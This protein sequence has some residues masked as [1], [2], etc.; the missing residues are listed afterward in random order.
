[1]PPGLYPESARILA[2]SPPKA[3]ALGIALALSHVCRAPRWSR[4]AVKQLLQWSI[5]V[6]GLSMDVREVLKAGAEG[7]LFAAATIV[8]SFVL[9][10]LLGRWLKTD[11]KL[12]TLLSAGTAICGGS[13]IAAVAPV[14]AASSAQTSVAL[15]VVFVLNG[16][17]LYIFPPLGHAL[18]LTQHQFGTWAAVAIH[19]TSSVVGAAAVYG[20]GALQTAVAVKLSRAL[21]IAPVVLAAA[22]WL[23]RRRGEGDSEARVK[24]PIP[25]FIGL[26]IIACAINGV[27][28]V[29]EP[30]HTD[31]QSIGKAGMT[32][33]L[34]LIGLGLSRAAMA[35]VGWRPLVQAVVVW[36]VLSVVSLVVIKAAGYEPPG[37]TPGDGAPA[38]VALGAR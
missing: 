32:M 20:Q 25:W 13:A 3:L 2:A 5:V 8:G 7:L 19:D 23:R 33:A 14:I 26:F 22:W 35:A 28:D 1:M 27:T 9:G 16:I 24:P 15:A 34:F 6:L 31:I 18:G 37:A 17:A 10:G 4:A 21:W 38:S 12:T 11:G 29:L 36:I 30:F